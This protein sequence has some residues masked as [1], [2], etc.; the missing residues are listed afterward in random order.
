MA[1]RVFQTKYRVFTITWQSHD[2]HMSC[3]LIRR[4]GIQCRIL[5]LLH[6]V[7]VVVVVGGGGAV[8]VG[9]GVGVGGGGE[10]EDENDD[11]EA[12]IFF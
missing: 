2:H 8:I 11:E 3:P 1:I 6:P 10:A 9:V 4:K 12:L 5:V 7:V